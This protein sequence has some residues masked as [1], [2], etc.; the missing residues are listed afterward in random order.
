MYCLNMLAIALELALDDIVYEDIATKFF[1]H[2]L[3]IAD[4]M[5]HIGKK[6][7]GLWDEGDGFYYDVLHLPSG[8]H[9]PLK[10]RS[11]VGLIPLFALET[12]EASLLDALPGFKK[13]LEWF[14]EHR[15]D[16]AR[17]V[18]SLT[19]EGMGSRRLLAIVGPDKLRRV[20]AKLLDESEF[21]SEHGVRSLSR[22][23]SAHPYMLVTDGE[24]RSVDYEPAES[25]SGLFGGNSNWR[26][27]VW[28][29]VNF[30]IIESLQK[31][32][33]YFGDEYK[34]ECPTGS[35]NAMSLWEVS[36]ELSHRLI[37]LFT[38]NKSGRRPVFGDRA[39]LQHDPYWRDMCTF[40]EYFN[41]DDGTGIG[42]SHQTGWTAVVAKLIQQ[43]GEYCAAGK[44]P[45]P[46]AMAQRAAEG[47][48]A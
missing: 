41:G 29:P 14:I 34:V 48:K 46:T 17:N 22:Y 30:L 13:R 23:H 18:A 33:Y 28:F 37:R 47:A 32:H 9:E 11:M 44:I 16:L 12:L 24:E 7:I 40:N 6:E 26:G 8:H 27:P 21:L 20:L 2:F 35:G 39:T 4:A 15:P 3:R 43:C 45:E 31:F 10:V 25:R 5:N 19:T 1:E 38:R 36:A 42:A